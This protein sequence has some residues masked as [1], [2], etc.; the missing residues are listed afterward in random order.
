MNGRPHRRML[1]PFALFACVACTDRSVVGPEPAYFALFGG[2]LNE[3][4]GEPRHATAC[5]PLDPVRG[6]TQRHT[7]P[8]STTASIALPVG[9][10][11]APFPDA[12]G[13]AVQVARAGMLGV[14]YDD[15]L[16][17]PTGPNGGRFRFPDLTTGLAA[18]TWCRTTVG[19]QDAVL[20]IESYGEPVAGIDPRTIRFGPV[21]VVAT[22]TPTGRRVNIMLITEEGF[23]VLDPPPAAGEESVALRRL[24]T[25]V[26]TIRW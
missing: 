6:Q 25:Y 9:A 2:R 26:G 14:T 21:A 22:T 20:F 12:G 10:R 24:L 7:I 18:N 8:G 15:V 13:L 11:T 16:M 3:P 1:A 19:G 4:V 23:V 17:L 5:P